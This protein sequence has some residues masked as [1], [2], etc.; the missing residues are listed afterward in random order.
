MKKQSSLS[1]LNTLG[2]SNHNSNNHRCNGEQNG[3]GSEVGGG[4]ADDMVV[5]LGKDAKFIFF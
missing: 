1:S 3:L 2:D 5:A 4:N